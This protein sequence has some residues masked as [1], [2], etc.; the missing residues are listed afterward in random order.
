MKTYKVGDTAS[1]GLFWRQLNVFGHWKLYF[2]V[3]ALKW[4]RR[5][6]D[7][8]TDEFVTAWWTL[9]MF[10]SYERDGIIHR[11]EFGSGWVIPKTESTNEE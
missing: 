7:V 1:Y 5:G 9:I 10:V 8:T 3:P 4:K 11:I 6:Y 2:M